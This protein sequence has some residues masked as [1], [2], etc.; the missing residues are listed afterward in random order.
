MPAA[1]S[2]ILLI[3]AMLLA[4]LVSGGT[5]P[6]PVLAQDD[7]ARFDD[8]LR[9][10]ANQTSAAGPLAG[11]L[12]Q[13][14]GFNTTAGAGVAVADFSATVAFV[15][16]AETDAPPWDVGISFRRDGNVVQQLVIDSLG[17]WYDSPYP[18][19]TEDSGFVVAFDSS[20]GARNTV[21]L[22]VE[23]NRALFGVNG[24]FVAG[25]D[26]PDTGVAADVEVGTGY[27]VGSVV[28]GRAIRYEDFEV[29]PLPETD[30]TAIAPTATAAVETLTPEPTPVTTATPE[31][32]GVPDEDADL[33]ASVLAAQAD[34]EP[35]SGPYNAI[36]REV[37]GVVMVAWA[38]VN[39]AE[40][41]ASGT[42]EV[43]ADAGG[44]AWD[45]GFMFGTSPSGTLRIAVDAQRQV[46]FSVGAGGPAVVGQASGLRTNPGE[47]N[48]L[49][50][51]VAGDRA[52]LGVN[53]ELAA[54]ADLPADATASDVGFGSG[55]Y[56]DQTVADRLLAFDDFAVR[57]L[58]PSAL[59]ATSS[60]TGPTAEQIAEFAALVADME[61]VA[62]VAGPFSGRL[63]E[64]TQGSV[65]LAP[66]GVSLADFGASAT[67]V[68]PDNPTGA[69]WDSG[70]RFRD[71]GTNNNRIVIDSLGDVYVLLAGEEARKV[72]TAASYDAAAGGS[73]TLHLFVDGDEALFG[74][75]GELVAAI[76][77]GAAPVASDVQIGTGFF[78][79]DF[80]VGRVT[81]YR[82]FQVWEMA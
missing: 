12:V 65:P 39:L 63:V 80:V 44:V 67:F 47:T 64:A 70:F 7:A 61:N 55:F 49:D 57:D 6:M 50:L 75:N 15:N 33:F 79:E 43:P 54:T 31:P 32:T 81:D 62:P 48:T 41:H 19:G 3:V 71:D 45:V 46:F 51:M 2:R 74:V 82:D 29:W 76:E 9:A 8:V 14:E 42:A 36:L 10:R 11:D 1:L 35:I 78:S 5:R 13:E 28:D 53:G 4:V 66:A 69:L 52:W 23:G 16:P 59:G 30:T 72:A 24:E 18:A 22:V 38:D 20:P 27:F 73:N 17:L 26:L 58:D 77:L 37:A 34:V 40:F 25:F 68:N 21:D 60:T 56:S